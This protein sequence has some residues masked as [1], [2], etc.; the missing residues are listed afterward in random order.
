MKYKLESL[1]LRNVHYGSKKD[2]KNKFFIQKVNLDLKI[3]KLT[4]I[5]GPSGSGKVI[6][7]SIL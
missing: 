4:A 5:L 7:L 2:E 1:V 3:G 6:K